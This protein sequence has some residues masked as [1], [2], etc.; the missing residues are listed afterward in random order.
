MEQ[1]AA[2]KLDVMRLHYGVKDDRYQKALVAERSAVRRKMR[3]QLGSVG[4]DLDQ[5]GLPRLGPRHLRQ[6][7]GLWR[8]QDLA[9]PLPQRTRIDT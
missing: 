3:H 4:T 5:D 6:T 1:P 2:L 8:E 7:A 9:D